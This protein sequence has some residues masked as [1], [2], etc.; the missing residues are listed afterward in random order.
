MTE[1]LLP[2]IKASDMQTFEAAPGATNRVVRLDERGIPVI[3]GVST[4]QPGTGAQEHRHPHWQ[5]FVVFEG[6]GVY[7]LDGVEVIAEAGDVVAVP[8]NAL[9][10]F[11]ADGDAPLRHVGIMEPHKFARARG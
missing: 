8:P 11:R 9:H 3:V 6:R 1:Q 2:L 10:G 4:Y 5:V 7:S